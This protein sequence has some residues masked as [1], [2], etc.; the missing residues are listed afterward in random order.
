MSFRPTRLLQSAAWLTIAAVACGARRPSRAPVAAPPPHASAPGCEGIAERFRTLLDD[1][2]PAAGPSPPADDLSRALGT[3]GRCAWRGP[4]GAWAQEVL[5]LEPQWRF[6]REGSPTLLSVFGRW[7]LVFVPSDGR[8]VAAL[9]EVEGHGLYF[10][11]S[12][13]PSIPSD[14]VF[15]F[16]RDG[17]LEVA[18]RREVPRGPSWEPPE[19]RVRV[20]MFTVRGGAIEPY[21]PAAAFPVEGL[22][23]A[24]GDGRPDLVLSPPY[25]TFIE[26]DGEVDGPRLFAHSLPD[27]TFTTSDA[28]VAASLFAQCPAP[29]ERL[30]VPRDPGE[31]R[32]DRRGPY[33]FS[34]P[35][36]DRRRT[37]LHVACA[38]L[39][40]ASAAEV[41]AA[42]EREHP[43][44]DTLPCS[45][46]DE[47]RRLAS[48]APPLD[49]RSFPAPLR[50]P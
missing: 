20:T 26:C 37:A 41:V 28:A 12:G 23:D 10:S 14:G 5:S 27:G 8:P 21:P 7:A 50:G 29:P 43:W 34:P 6:T 40:G 45:Y 17:V 44:H 39:W 32:R 47:L 4:G 15:D 38:R 48:R 33:G 16:D 31:P 11:D 30:V 22:S 1:A 42:I 25:R 49:L 19:G 36:F 35:G 3:V 9:E 2:R 13:A 46:S 24:D 18:L